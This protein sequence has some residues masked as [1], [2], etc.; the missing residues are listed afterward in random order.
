MIIVD[1]K[2]DEPSSFTSTF[3]TII[4]GCSLKPPKGEGG[5]G[6]LSTDAGL[7]GNY[8]LGLLVYRVLDSLGKAFVNV[9]ERSTSILNI[10]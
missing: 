1:R 3:I 5:T 10:R 7:C 8:V 4:T 6:G 2:P 9:L